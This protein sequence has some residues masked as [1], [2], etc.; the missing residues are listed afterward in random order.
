MDTARILQTCGFLAEGTTVTVVKAIS[1]RPR[2]MRNEGF[3]CFASGLGF[4][5]RDQEEIASR[6]ISTAGLD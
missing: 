2:P 5:H 4:K 1:P 6:P 3:I